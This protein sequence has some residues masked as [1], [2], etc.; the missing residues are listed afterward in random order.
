MKN[1]KIM[2]PPEFMVSKANL[3]RKPTDVPFGLWQFHY[4]E[5]ANWKS[6]FNQ[7]LFFE[8][9]FISQKC[10]SI[11][12][13]L[14]QPA[15]QTKK[16]KWKNPETG[17][18]EEVKRIEWYRKQIDKINSKLKLAT[19]YVTRTQG[20][21]GYV[22]NKTEKRPEVVQI[23]NDVMSELI[24]L[25]WRLEFDMYSVGLTFPRGEDPTTALMKS[26]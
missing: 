23:L 14:I 22:I 10:F 3:H 8:D 12:F 26:Q 7:A 17:L 5:I 11:L 24:T 9:P 1:S 18:F 4:Q 6:H 15:I 19:P 2:V 13:G 16:D 25:H 20:Q 21:T